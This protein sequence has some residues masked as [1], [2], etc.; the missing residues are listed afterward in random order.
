MP[1]SQLPLTHCLETAVN[2]PHAAAAILQSHAHHRSDLVI[3][4]KAYWP[5][6][7]NVN[8][9]SLSRKH[10][11]ESVN[12]SLKRFDTDYIDIFFCHRFDDHT[13]VEEIQR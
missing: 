13:P 4:T 11:T 10:I 7:D 2:A 3:S 12:K 5:M 9:R 1:S 6:S 8:D